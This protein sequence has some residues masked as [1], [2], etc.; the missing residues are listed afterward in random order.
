M[1]LWLHHLDKQT[2]NRRNKMKTLTTNQ[3]ICTQGTGW[4]QGMIE[5]AY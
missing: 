2:I 3:Q 5:S 4:C 1:V